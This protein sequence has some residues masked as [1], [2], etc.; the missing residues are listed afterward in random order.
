MYCKIHS[1]QSSTKHIKKDHLLDFLVRFCT[2]K[3]EYNLNCVFELAIIPSTMKQRG[4]GGSYLFG[5]FFSY[6][7]SML[8]AQ[9]TF[10]WF[11]VLVLVLVGSESESDSLVQSIFWLG[12]FGSPPRK[13][14]QFSWKN[15]GEKKA[16]SSHW[17]FHTN[18]ILCRLSNILTLLLT[19]LYSPLLIFSRPRPLRLCLTLFLLLLLSLFSWRESRITQRFFPLIWVP[20][21]S[22]V[23]WSLSLVCGLVLVFA[24]RG[25]WYFHGS[26]Q[27]W[28]V[29]E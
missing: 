7:C 24:T 13:M 29:V 23:V 2:W 22:L 12:W 25:S 4:S 19:P 17:G 27:N 1:L 3:L 28:L 8:N 21:F 9:T 14:V 26:L 10:L 5:H 20:L 6:Q 18:N 11:L 16:N 15:W